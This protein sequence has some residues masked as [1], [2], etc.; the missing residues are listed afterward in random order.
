MRT[1]HN[2]ETAP[3]ETAPSLRHAAESALYLLAQNGSSQPSDDSE[4]AGHTVWSLSC[5]GSA[6]SH[7]EVRCVGP[8]LPERVPDEVI[9]PGAIA[10]ERPCF[11][12]Y[13]LTVKAPILVLDLY[14][15]STSK[16]RIMTFANGDWEQEI[17]DMAGR[18]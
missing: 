9:R 3:I 8:D 11:G 17:A 15:S 13:R 2:I 18:G 5:V 4:R 1:Y 16:L 12:T 7:I 10:D 14:W 6:G